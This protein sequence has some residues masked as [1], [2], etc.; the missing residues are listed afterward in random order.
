MVRKNSNAVDFYTFGAILH[1]LLILL[2][3]FYSRDP[4]EIMDNILN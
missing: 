1:E 4:V 2:S 3:S